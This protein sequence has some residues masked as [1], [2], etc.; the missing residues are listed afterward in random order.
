[1][2]DQNGNP[3]QFGYSDLPA[4]LQDIEEFS[5]KI[6]QYGFDEDMEITLKK[7]LSWNT[8]KILL[9]KFQKRINDNADVNQKTLTIVYYGAHG[10]MNDNQS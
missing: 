5:Q 2:L 10:M 1:M 4:V 6:Q 3:K 9:T 7:N 8:L